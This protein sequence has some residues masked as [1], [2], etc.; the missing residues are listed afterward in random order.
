MEI[1]VPRAASLAGILK[2]GINQEVYGLI[3]LLFFHV[4][5]NHSMKWNE[6]FQIDERMSLSG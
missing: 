2:F 6:P 1:K 4:W 5:D 3:Y